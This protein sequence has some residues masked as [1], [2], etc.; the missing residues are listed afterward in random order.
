MNTTRKRLARPNLRGILSTRRG[1]IALALLCAAAAIAI[2]VFALGKYQ[3]SVAKTAQQDTVLVATAEITKGSSADV[4]VSQ[5]LYKV[6][7]VLAT[8]VAPGAINNAGSLT[9][10]VAASNILPGQQLT[11]TDFTATAPGVTGL[12]TP[13]E[14]AVAV[15]LDPTHG[16]AGTLRTGDHVDVYASVSGA[17]SSAAAG[18]GPVVSLLVANATILPSSAGSASGGAIS[19]SGA[20]GSSGG[21]VLLGVSE[22]LSPRVMWVVDNGKVWLELRGINSTDPSPTI[23]G[24]RQALL[25]NYLTTTPTYAAPAATG[26]KR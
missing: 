11:S 26:V 16:V 3:N 12:L 17:A 1:A 21:T 9:G 22:Q 4:I 13:T 5:R 15:T 20:G 19:S 25:G 14:R 24:L 2:L 23:T 8:G 18:G 7:P 6:V 10:Q